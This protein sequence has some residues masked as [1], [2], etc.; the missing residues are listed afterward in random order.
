MVDQ[1]V[2]RLVNQSLSWLVGRKGGKEG[3]REREERKEKER[4]RVGEMGR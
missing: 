4:L 3:G 2:G 1:S